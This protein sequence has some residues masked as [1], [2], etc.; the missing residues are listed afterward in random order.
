[1]VDPIFADPRLAEV[2]D[3]LDPD[4]SDLEP[5]AALVDEVGARAVLDIGC[6]TGTFACLLADRGVAVTALDPAAAS[7]AVARRKPAAELVEW[8]VG[9]VSTLPPLAVDLVTMTANVAQVFG[10]DAE[11]T[12][13]LHAARHALRPGGRLAFESRDPARRAWE[14]WD[15]ERSYTSAVVPGIGPVE[16]WVEVLAVRGDLVSFRWTFV[17]GSDGAVLTSDSTL[18][19]RTRAELVGSVTAAGLVVDD[20]R[21]APDRPGRELVVIAHRPD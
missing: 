6:G 11:W 8:V 9:D 15:R 12:A 1:M 19:F 3:P 17:F 18:R 14:E 10:T 13:T 4:R 21:D 16:T 5:Y 7:I 2:Y 20:V